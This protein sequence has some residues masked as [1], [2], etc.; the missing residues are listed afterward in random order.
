MKKNYAFCEK[1]Y[2]E[3]EYDEEEK[4]IESKI[5]NQVYRYK[6]KVA[7]CVICHQE[8]MNHDLLDYNLKQFDHVYRKKNHLITIEQ[9]HTLG[10]MYPLSFDHLALFLN[11]NKEVVVGYMQGTMPSMEHSKALV[12]M[13]RDPYYLKSLVELH[14]KE[15]KG[16]FFQLDKAIKKQIIQKQSSLQEVIDYLLF[17]NSKITPLVLQKALYYIQGFYYA[18]YDTFLFNEEIEAWAHGPV[19]RKVYQHYKEYGYQSIKAP[20]QEV[21]LDPQTKAIVDSVNKNLCNLNGKLLENMTHL[22]TPWL[23]SSKKAVHPDL[24]NQVIEKQKIAVY[25]KQI[26][27]DYHLKRPQ[28]ISIYVKALLRKI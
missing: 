11:T 22:E 24:Y 1:C 20:K 9:L 27:Q 18:F 16:D 4:Q 2:Q 23:E 14:Q 3:V 8:V 7:Y 19:I 15:M 25:F 10:K 6:G 28:D 17:H 13:L 21:H 26:K 12:K 5:Q